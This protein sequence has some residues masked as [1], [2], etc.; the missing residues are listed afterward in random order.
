MTGRVRRLAFADPRA[1]L[2]PTSHRALPHLRGTR[3]DPARQHGGVAVNSGAEDGELPPAGR[4]ERRV[5]F[6]VVT[7]AVRV[8][9]GHFGEAGVAHHLPEQRRLHAGKI[10]RR[11][12]SEL[13][14]AL[15]IRDRRRRAV[16]LRAN[17][18]LHSARSG[19]AQLLRAGQ[20]RSP[21]TLEDDCG[22][23]S[24]QHRDQRQRRDERSQQGHARQTHLVQPPDANSG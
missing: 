24:E 2:Q 7:R 17:L 9:E 20:N 3:R 12:H 16:E 10:V 23:R 1:V 6:R 22:Q 18:R 13:D 14:L 5:A 15:Q 8:D 19:V 11:Y 21:R 4:R